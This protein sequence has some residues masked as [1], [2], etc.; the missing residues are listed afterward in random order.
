MLKLLKKIF[1]HKRRKPIID[2]RRIR[3]NTWTTIAIGLYHNYVEY[4]KIILK[5]FTVVQNICIYVYVA[6]NKNYLIKISRSNKFQR[7]ES[8]KKFFWEAKLD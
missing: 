7:T 1:L 8:K 5:S 2:L 6:I 4:Y 3:T